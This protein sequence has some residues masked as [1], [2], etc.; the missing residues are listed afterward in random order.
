MKLAQL[1]PGKPEIF[2]T[3]QGEGPSSGIP[4]VFVRFSHC[5]L[6]CV[7]CDSD[8]TW[9]WQGTRFP[10]VRDSDPDYQKFDRK[11]QILEL[12]VS[13]AVE[14]IVGFKC[15]N[16]VLTGGEPLLHQ[17]DL[18]ALIHALDAMGPNFRFEVETNGT[19]VPECEL[20]ENI[21]QFNVSPKLA[22]SQVPKSQRIVDKSMM[23]FAS[24]PNAYFKFVVD[25]SQDIE[26][27]DQLVSAYSIES[28]RVLLMPQGT[29]SKVLREKGPA[30]VEVCKAR[31]FRFSD[32]LH[33]H[34]YGDKRGV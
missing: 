7:W 14:F 18:L 31:G 23:Y 4:S 12:E 5:N 6:H 16:I 1:S 25:S 10:H 3:I 27:V 33:V 24:Q 9:N 34:L 30:L 28:R 21:D 15:D 11:Q 20:A 13:Q 19:R 32:R 17:A 8:Y 2:F 26:E 29:S 22:N